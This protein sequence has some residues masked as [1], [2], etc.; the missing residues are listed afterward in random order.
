MRAAV[1]DLVP[2]ERRGT[3]YGTFTAVYGL[4]W[5]GG[6]AAIG[7]LYAASVGAVE[8]FVVATQ[9]AA[10]LAALPLVVTRKPVGAN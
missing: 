6:G 10:L 4:A 5:L 1:A 7:A 3:A 2:A 9:A 8:G